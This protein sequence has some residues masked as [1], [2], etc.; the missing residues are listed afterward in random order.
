MQ[1]HF[2]RVMRLI[3]FWLLVVL[4]VLVPA[5]A[6]VATSMFCPTVSVA[7]AKTH[8]VT[9]A[10]KSVNRHGALA[11]PHGRAPAAKAAIDKL[12]AQ[13]DLQQAEHCCDA[14]PC[15]HCGSC[16][17]C[18]SMGTVVAVASADLRLADL[19]LPDPGGPR[20][21]FLLAGQERPPRTC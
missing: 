17:S 5:T 11:A 16:G 2:Q 21:E 7:K 14:T 15:T 18:A 12:T 9:V 10:A 13:G 1:H 20:A 8:G 19:V 6:S 3:G 4:A